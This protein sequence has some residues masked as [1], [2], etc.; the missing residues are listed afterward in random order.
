MLCSA[1]AWGLFKKLRVRSLIPEWLGLCHPG[2]AFSIPKRGSW[3][4]PA[5]SLSL[6]FWEIDRALCPHPF[7]GAG[8]SSLPCT[9]QALLIALL[10][11]LSW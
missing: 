9:P 7:P 1:R 8:A 5:F 2:P 6:S 10:A 3:F 11:G 4:L